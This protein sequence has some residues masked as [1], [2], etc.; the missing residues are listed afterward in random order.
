MRFAGAVFVLLWLT[1][2]APGQSVDTI[3][4]NKDD[5]SLRDFVSAQIQALRIE[6]LTRD[7]AQEQ[8]VAAAL[9]AA[10]KAATKAEIASDKRFDSVNEFR[11]TLTDQ[12]QNFISKAEAVALLSAASDRIDKN[13]EAVRLLAARLND[14]DSRGQGQT[15][16]W[17]LIVGGLLAIITVAGFVINIASRRAQSTKST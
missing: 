1:I 9:A 11:E 4:A 6:M 8:G 16:Q 5:V 3:P 15:E 2:A 17:L 12:A 10:D 7:E 13:E 14:M